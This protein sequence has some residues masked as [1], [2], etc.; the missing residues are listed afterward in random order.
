METAFMG[1][2]PGASG[3]CVVITSQNQ[4][5]EI[6]FTKSTDKEIWQFI[7]NM[8]FKYNIKCVSEMVSAMPGQGVT[9]MFSFGTNV[10]FIKGLLVAAG[11]SYEEKVPRTWQKALGIQPRYK[12]K[13]GESGVEESKTDFKKRLRQKAEQLYPNH[14]ITADTADAILIAHFC[15]QLYK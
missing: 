4:I 3:A 7:E 12:P 9:S 14:K 15:R 5:H 2:D 13:K 8:S 10:G 11:I 1:I 6:R